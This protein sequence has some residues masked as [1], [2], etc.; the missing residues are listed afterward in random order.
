MFLCIFIII[1]QILC[2]SEA[3]AVK[4]RIP[5]SRPV[6]NC[7]IASHLQGHF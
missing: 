7:P 5:R 6:L 2:G 1:T 4:E 3:E